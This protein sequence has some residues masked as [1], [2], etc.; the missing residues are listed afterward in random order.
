VKLPKGTSYDQLLTEQLDSLVPYIND[1]VGHYPS[2]QPVWSGQGVEALAELYM[3]FDG[4]YR[5]DALKRAVI[6]SCEDLTKSMSWNGGGY[7][8]VYVRDGDEIEQWIDEPNYAWLWL[9]P[10]AACAEIEGAPRFAEIADDLFDY[11]LSHYGGA[12]WIAAREWSSLLGF[13]GYYLA[14]KNGGA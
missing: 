12:E 2:A 4:R 14:R 7:D 3:G 13:G 11:A 8:L 1:E 9:N 5:S 6:A 10:L